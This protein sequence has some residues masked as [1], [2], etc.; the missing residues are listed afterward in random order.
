MPRRDLEG[1]IARVACIVW[2]AASLHVLLFPLEVQAQTAV[3]QAVPSEE[4]RVYTTCRI[5]GARPVLDGR[6]DEAAWEAVPWT[7]DF[8]QRS[9]VQNV[10]PSQ[11]TE[12]KILYDDEAL[13]IAYRAWDTEPQLVKRQL[14]RR[15]YFPGDWVEINIDS[16]GDHTTAFS[17]TV[18]VSGVRGD[19]FVSLDGDN[20]D[21][22]WDPV[23]EAATAVDDQGWTAEARI[24]F[25]QLRYG[26]CAEQVWGIQVNRRIFRGEERSAWQRV[27]DDASGWVSRF[28]ELRG[29]TGLRAQRQIEIMPYVVGKAERFEEVAGDPFLDGHDEQADIGV[30]GKI[31]VT[32]NLVLDLTV[33]PDFGQVEADP[34]EVNLSAFETYFAEKRPFFI[35]GSNIFDNGVAEAI[36][37]GDFT[38]DNLFYSRRI[39]RAPQGAARP[40][41]G[42]TVRMPSGTTILGA[43]KLSGKTSGGLSIG[44]LE[45]V[46]AEE[47]AELDVLEGALGSGGRAHEE[48]VEPL[49]NYF[50]VRVQQDLRE[51]A[52]T[53]GA[54]V[55]AVNRDIDE[56]SLEFMH[57]AAYAGGI[58]LYHAWRDRTY[59]V[60]AKAFASQVRGDEQALLRTQTS[61]AHY[62]QRP[63]VEHADL[64][65]TRTSLSGHAGSFCVG[66]SSSGGF[67]FQTGLAWRSPGFEINDL[68][69]LRHAG[70]I[71]QFGWVSYRVNDP[72]SVFNS[73]QVNGNE[74][75]NY[76]YEGLHTSHTLNVNFSASFK[77]QWGLY[78][79]L[80]R[81]PAYKS[82][83]SLRGGPAARWPGEWE[84][85]LE[86]GTDP[87]RWISLTPG[88]YAA[89]GDENSYRYRETWAS[90]TMRPSDALRFVLNPDYARMD[91]DLQYVTTRS[92]QG[93]ARYIFGSLSQETLG[94]VFRADI[95]LTPDLTIQYYGQPFISSGTFDGFR[96]IT[97]PRAE[98]Y[99]DRF[100]IY[101]TGAAPDGDIRFDAAQG[102]YLV[103]ED[104]DGADDYSFAD[105]DF[106]VKEFNSNLVLR[107]EYRPGSL[108]YVVWSQGREQVAP[109]GGFDFRDDY[110]DLFALHPHD[111]FL[112]KV[113]RW[114]A[115]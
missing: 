34:A 69:Y 50:A 96:R 103:D 2:T 14:G 110:G 74:W 111:I 80:T 45:S 71:N 22:S 112:I 86:L 115:W 31:G 70:D 62:F 100:Q 61:S 29:I 28:G 109:D 90:L 106:E 113:S 19:E 49:S 30:D 15:D 82:I 13:Y 101:E 93:A 23:W 114:F 1:R 36:T 68:G 54:M 99:E 91:S 42:E 107:W 26:E 16:R 63:D 44:V 40:A 60:R 32:G 81:T 105:P 104:R 41:E 57:S 77:N 76:D 8:T 102:A 25:S 73:F 65:S 5:D 48:T 52:T 43:A 94:I 56:P 33:N 64:D 17:F 97:V 84:R 18:S 89:N 9:P 37:G 10:P 20:W 88:I 11:Q 55:T 79:N 67:R 92:F 53:L 66:R 83:T 72:F 58:D 21:S 75:T 4:R 38:R 24:P 95:C 51:G 27:P 59:Y 85:C 39:G 108:L 12:F 7:G 87:R 35:E 98:R 46:T 3:G 47:R 6:I 78:G